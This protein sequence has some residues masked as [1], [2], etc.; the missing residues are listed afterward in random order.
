MAEPQRSRGVV[1]LATAYFV[2]SGAC[3]LV[4]EVL[5]FKRFAHVWGSS[6]DWQDPATVTEHIRRIRRK[7]EDDPDNPKFL[8]TVRSVGYRFQP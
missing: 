8:Q 4:Y 1:L 5:W 6:S 3:G 2:L 7:V